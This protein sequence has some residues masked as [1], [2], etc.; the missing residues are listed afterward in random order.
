MNF[1]M[2]GYS[3]GGRVVPT[4]TAG[5]GAIGESGGFLQRRGTHPGVVESGERRLTLDLQHLSPKA[6]MDPD[7]AAEVDLLGCS[8]LLS[9]LLPSTVALSCPRKQCCT[10]NEPHWSVR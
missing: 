3:E 4:E 5:A 9:S 6:F 8:I 1:L 7:T 10:I 2:K